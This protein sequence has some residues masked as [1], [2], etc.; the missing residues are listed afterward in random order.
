MRLELAQAL[1]NRLETT[2]D[3]VSL[4]LDFIN[5]LL[6]NPTIAVAIGCIGDF[7]NMQKDL[8]DEIRY[9]SLQ[10]EVSALFDLLSKTIGLN[11]INTPTTYYIF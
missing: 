8:I 10:D 2:T 7:E 11:I 6:N 1:V 3:Y 5:P 9:S 4:D